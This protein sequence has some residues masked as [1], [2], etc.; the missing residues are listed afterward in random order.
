MVRELRFDLLIYI[1]AQVFIT[2]TLCQSILWGSLGGSLDFLQC[3]IKSKVITRS[4]F[5]KIT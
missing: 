5:G 2:V 4:R 3:L 1:S